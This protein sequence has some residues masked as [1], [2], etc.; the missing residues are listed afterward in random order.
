MKIDIYN[1][2][3]IKIFYNII[4]NIKHILF[5]NPRFLYNKMHNIKHIF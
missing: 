5:K 3:F 2:I 4:K 1:E